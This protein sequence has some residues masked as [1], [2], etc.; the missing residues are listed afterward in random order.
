MHSNELSNVALRICEETALS[1]I[2]KVGEGSYKE[3]FLVKQDDGSP[4]AL[5]VYKLG[6][7]KERTNR[8]INAMQRCSHKAIAK[9][10]SISN[11]EIDQ[12]NYLF[13]REEYLG[14]GTLTRHLTRHGTL[15]TSTI[16]S[17]GAQLISAIE[18]IESLGLVHR[19]IK[20]DNILFRQ[21]TSEAV[22]TDF[23]IVRDLH[24]D[25]LTTTWLIRGPGTPYF[26]A[27]EQLNNDK[28]L[29][30]WRTDQFSLGVLLSICAI[31]EHPFNAGDLSIIEVIESV[32][33]REPISDAIKESLSETGL[34]CIEKMVGAWPAQRFRT[35]Q[36][37]TNAWVEQGDD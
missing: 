7:R 19:D 22:V 4:I 3:T 17:L 29:I 23:G 5:K 6:S 35:P 16:L 21:G 10:Y 11:I 18:H 9:L 1:F 14:G 15:D 8:E 33:Q 24:A 12:Q 28:D 2:K 26:A 30:D 36:R 32:A 13:A 31:G 34:I 25:S 27:P 37:L 20:P